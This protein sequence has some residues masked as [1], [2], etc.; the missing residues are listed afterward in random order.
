M[1]TSVR[2][3]V[4][5]RLRLDPTSTFVEHEPC[6]S[7]CAVRDISLRYPTGELSHVS[8]SWGSTAS[9]FHLS[10]LKHLNLWREMC[11]NKRRGRSICENTLKRADK[12]YVK[13]FFCP[14]HKYRSTEK[15][16]IWSRCWC[17]YRQVS[18]LR[19]ECETM[20]R[21]SAACRLYPDELTCLSCDRH[22]LFL[23]HRWLLNGSGRWRSR[24][25]QK[26]SGE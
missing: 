12:K 4:C 11:K 25:Q 19:T 13:L 10:E 5:T 24:L 2:E 23:G 1:E 26:Q 20:R 15:H 7:E 16:S 14:D 17:F 9:I 6:D 8:A 3:S 18:H 21:N 22:F